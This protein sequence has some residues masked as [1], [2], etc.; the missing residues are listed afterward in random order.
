MFGLLLALAT[1]FSATQIMSKRRKLNGIE[2]VCLTLA[3]SVVFVFAEGLALSFFHL[4]DLLFFALAL[5]AAALLLYLRRLEVG[6]KFERIDLFVLVVFAI[7]FLLRVYPALTDPMPYGSYDVIQHYA[8]AMETAS[9][10]GLVNDFP[11]YINWYGNS[12]DN[13]NGTWIYP[14]GT[15]VA[16]ASMH[17]LSGFDWPA[18]IN[19]FSSFFD[20]LTML[21]IFLICVEVFGGKKAGVVAGLLF[22]VSTRNLSSL[23]FGQVAYEFGIMLAALSLYFFLLQ[24]LVKSVFDVFVRDYS[25]SFFVGDLN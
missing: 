1:G 10:N 7:G 17:A 2:T 22:A 19:V 4:L 11:R 24:M 8:M 21:V 13:V 23:Y 18:T 16:L 15:S 6:F 9:H 25:C 3:L 20:S 14:P 12:Q 5:S